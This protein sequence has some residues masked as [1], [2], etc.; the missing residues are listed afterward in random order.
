[1]GRLHSDRGEHL[2][3]EAAELRD[4][5]GEDRLRRYPFDVPALAGL[6]RM[7]LDR[8]ITFFVGENGS[9]KST[10]L[11]AI[12]LAAGFGAEGGSRNFAPRT[13]D[14]T[15][16]VRALADALRL[17]WTRKLTRGFFL[18]AES[19]FN[20][21]TRVDELDREPRPRERLLD[22]YGG[23]SLHAQ[24]HGESF[25]ALAK[26]RFRPGGL[27][28]LDEPEAALSPQ[29]Q[30]SLLVLLH[31]LMTGDGDTQL[32]IATHSPILLGYPEARIL[33][34]DGEEV[35]PSEWEETSAVQVTRDFLTN[36]AFWLDRLLGDDDAG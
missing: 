6:E 20:V 31:G 13:T 7:T 27:Y 28:L 22:A 30:L 21:A 10:W 3:A 29:R 33:S 18:R 35:A 14:S 32:L 16:S 4:R 24:S 17:S 23:V 2:L 34:F 15:S 1:M 26:H 19:F 25:L 9:G 36:R 5:V 11:E 12:A 8:R